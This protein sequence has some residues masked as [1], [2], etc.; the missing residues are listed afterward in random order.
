M[1]LAPAS[2]HTHMTS[3]VALFSP[4]QAPTLDVGY[5]QGHCRES[6]GPCCGGGGAFPQA[7]MPRLL[8]YPQSQE[9]CSNHALGRRWRAG[10][11]Q[12]R[13]PP[14]DSSQGWP[15]PP[16]PQGSQ[17][18]CS[19]VARRGH[20]RA[21]RSRGCARGIA[22]ALGSLLW[23]CSCGAGGP[24]PE[25]EQTLLAVPALPAH[26]RRPPRLPGRRRSQQGVCGAF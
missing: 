20:G 19:V 16:R 12:L 17:G 7:E 6:G 22:G 11:R 23:L 26:K 9:T 4:W 15:G 25:S 3:S 1:H 10:G 21:A 8:V 2:Q 13:L 24:F 5:E 14:C 18:S